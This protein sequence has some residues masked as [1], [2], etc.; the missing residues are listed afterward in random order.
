MLF[1]TFNL[2][3]LMVKEEVIID[4]SCLL[5]IRLTERNTRGFFLLLI[6]SIQDLMLGHP[7]HHH[8]SQIFFMSAMFQS[9]T[10][11]SSSPLQLLFLGLELY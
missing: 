9:V 3:L 11:F 10:I 2:R 8:S 4:G 6:N 7:I 1:K 5:H